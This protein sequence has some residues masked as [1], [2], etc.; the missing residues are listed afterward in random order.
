MSNYAGHRNAGIVGAIVGAVALYYGRSYVHITYQEIGLSAAVIFIFSLFPDIDIK[1]AP[2]KVFY[3]I[4]AIILGSCYYTKQYAIGNLLGLIAIIP[5]ITKHR[6]FFHH[7]ITAFGLPA[8]VFYIH[9][10]EVIE[11]KLAILIYVSAVFGYLI[12]LIKDHQ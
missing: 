2:S 11:L 6:G 3:T 1:S 5:Q 10:I 8:S 12:H 7:P 9:Y 4:V